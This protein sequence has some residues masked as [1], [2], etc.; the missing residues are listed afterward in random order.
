MA[1][2]LNRKTIIRF[3][4]WLIAYWVLYY[5]VKSCSQ[6]QEWGLNLVISAIDILCLAGCAAL[7][8]VVIIPRLLYRRQMIRFLLSLLLLIVF[9]ALLMQILHSVWYSIAGGTSDSEQL[10]KYYYYQLFSSWW[11]TL[12]G[13]LCIIAFKLVEDQWLTINRYNQLQKEKAQ[14]E[15]NFLKAQI[16]PH[17]LFNSINSIFASIDRSNVQ[18]RDTVL[19]FSDMLR[20]QLYECNTDEISFEKEY[21]YIC[22]YIELQRLRKGDTL[23][24]VVERQG[25][26][27]GFLIAP[28]LLIPFIENAFKYASSHTSKK[29]LIRISCVLEDESFT[30][31]C[32]NTRDQILS[33]SLFEEGGIGINNVKRRLDLMYPGR[34]ELRIDNREDEFEVYLKLPAAPL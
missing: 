20:Y 11:I 7:L 23:E 33:R 6:Q 26:I 27:G 19:K 22:N 29:N 25:D 8:R 24:I 1:S 32:F 34:H 17:F 9:C 13:C 18:A 3:S 30:F 28:L 12:C 5:Y 15:L 21:A 14:T 10:F 4:S 2:L 16:N 31:Q